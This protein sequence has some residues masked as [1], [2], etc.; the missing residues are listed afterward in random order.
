MAAKIFTSLTNS[1]IR[2]AEQV[3]DALGSAEQQLTAGLVSFP[4]KSGTIHA[5]DP[6]GGIPLQGENSC[7]VAVDLRRWGALLTQ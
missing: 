1:E 2:P 7:F 5:V 3:R 4:V 6:R